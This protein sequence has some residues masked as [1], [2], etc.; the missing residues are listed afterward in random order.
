[1]Q[2]VQKD[3]MGHIAALFRGVED[4]M[5]IACLQGYMGEAFANRIPFPDFA[6]IVSGE[7]SF[8]GGDWGHSEVPMLLEN[9]FS[10]IPGDVTTAIY[11]DDAPGWR[12]LLMKQEAYSPREVMRYGIAQKD[13]NF[14]LEHLQKII[15]GLPTGYE[16]RAFDRGIYQQAM[17]EAWSRE[18]CETFAS[19]EDYLQRGFGFGILYQGKLVAG[20]STMT[21][22]DGG[23]ET[24]VATKE[25]HQRKGLAM[26]CAARF[27]IEAQ[28]RRV[29]PCWDAAN[30]TSKHMALQLGYEYRGDYTTVV[31]TRPAE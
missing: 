6:M 30:L 7:Y 19:A 13:Y 10:Y 8:F 16:L 27:I 18:F 9:L 31:L 2:K 14:D 25:G 12:E 1:M 28:A 3:E 24:Q 20:A 21:V 5:V 15:K 22:Y 4:S 23:T 17:E 26:I 11:A 29:R